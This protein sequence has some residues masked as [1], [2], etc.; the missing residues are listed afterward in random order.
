LN[1]TFELLAIVD[2]VHAEHDD[3]VRANLALNGITLEHANADKSTILVEFNTGCT[4][5]I[6]SNGPCNTVPFAIGKVDTTENGMIVITSSLG[7]IAIILVDELGI[8]VDLDPELNAEL[9]V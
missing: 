8:I 1:V 3:S 7:V 9:L 4:V 2:S 6:G 5:S